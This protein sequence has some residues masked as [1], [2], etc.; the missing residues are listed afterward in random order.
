MYILTI[1]SS[2]NIRF[3]VNFDFSIYFHLLHYTS[4]LLTPITVLSVNERRRAVTDVVK[5]CS[6]TPLSKRQ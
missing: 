2:E 1:F 5:T 6:L 3:S 4:E